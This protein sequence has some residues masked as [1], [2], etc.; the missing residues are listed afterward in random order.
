MKC[1]CAA[2]GHEFEAE[3]QGGHRVLVGDSTDAV[4]VARLMQSDR[5]ALVFTSPPY[6]VG[7][8]SIAGS[9]STKS[10]YLSTDDVLPQNEYTAFLVAIVDGMLAVA[11]EVMINISFVQSNK[12]SIIDLLA[13]FADRFKDVIFWKKSI[14]APHIQAGVINNLVEMI[15]CFGDGRR[16]FAHA[17]FSQGTYWNVIEGTNASSNEFAKLHKATFPTYLPKNLI[18][19]FCPGGGLV[20]DCF[21]GTGTTIIAAEETGRRALLMEIDP[22]YVDVSITRWQNFTGEKAVRDDGHL[23]SFEAA[24]AE[25]A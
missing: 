18:S 4:T 2:C 15:L 21:G 10:K 8:M 7:S 14:T 11:D 24:A 1:A 20:V 6:N 13:H 12:R 16:K 23:F 17:Q 25:A 3:P 9:E 5:A 22:A 19:N